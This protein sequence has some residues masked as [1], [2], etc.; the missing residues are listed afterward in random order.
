MPCDDMDW[1]DEVKKCSSCAGD[2]H[3]HFGD[4]NSDCDYWLIIH[5]HKCGISYLQDEWNELEVL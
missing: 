5:C 4:E 3:S 2:V 1:F